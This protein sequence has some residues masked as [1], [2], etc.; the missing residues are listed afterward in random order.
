MAFP[1]L[2]WFDEKSHDDSFS[3]FFSVPQAHLPSSSDEPRNY[4]SSATQRGSTD[5][6]NGVTIFPMGKVYKNNRCDY[7]IYLILI[8]FD[9][10]LFVEMYLLMYHLFIYFYWVCLHY[11]FFTFAVVLQARPP[12]HPH[13]R[14]T[15]LLIWR[16]KEMILNIQTMILI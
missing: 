14:I 16:S 5:V 6:N 12:L 3:I 2:I 10:T 4:S 8:K 11:F 15:I 13:C 7:I 9:N 1:V